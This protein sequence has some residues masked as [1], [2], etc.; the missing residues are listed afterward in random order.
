VSEQ[1]AQDLY[2]KII[3]K[4]NINRTFEGNKIESYEDLKKIE[5]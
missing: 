3:N 2:E 4:E 5:E 1:K